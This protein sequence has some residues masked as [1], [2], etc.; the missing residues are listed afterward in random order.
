M[1]LGHIGLLLMANEDLVNDGDF[2]T[3]GEGCPFFNAASGTIR[4]GFHKVRFELLFPERTSI[5]FPTPN[6]PGKRGHL[7]EFL[8]LIGGEV[9]VVGESHL[10]QPLSVF[11][12]LFP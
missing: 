8:F 2:V 3:D 10:P 4:D 12:D 6:P 11:R 1:C 5:V 7:M 9:L